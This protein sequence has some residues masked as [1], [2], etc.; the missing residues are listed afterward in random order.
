M[1]TDKDNSDLLPLRPANIDVAVTDQGN[2]RVRLRNEHID[3]QEITEANIAYLKAEIKKQ[4]SARDAQ[5]AGDS[6][7]ILPMTGTGKKTHKDMQLIFDCEELHMDKAPYGSLRHFGDLVIEAKKDLP[8]SHFVTKNVS[9]INR[10]KT[11][12]KALND[13]AAK[14]LAEQTDPEGPTTPGTGRMAG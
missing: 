4:L 8:R 7:D 14:H 9:I 12:D 1:A 10:D 5:N 13:T 6:K 11:L 2:L 3:S